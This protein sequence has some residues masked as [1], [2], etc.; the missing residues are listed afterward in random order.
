MDGRHQLTDL[1]ATV[2]KHDEL[3]KAG[4]RVLDLYQRVKLTVMALRHNLTREVLAES[5]DVSQ[6]IASRIIRAYTRP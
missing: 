2:H 3:P 5:F 6:S 4:S 1:R